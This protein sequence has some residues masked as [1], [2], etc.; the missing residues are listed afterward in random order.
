VIC[1]KFYYNSN[2]MKL[3]VKLINKEHE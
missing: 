1:Y 2:L 3:G